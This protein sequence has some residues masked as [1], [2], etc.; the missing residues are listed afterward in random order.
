M[1]LFGIPEKT[2]MRYGGVAHAERPARLSHWTGRALWERC[3][4]ARETRTGPH[5]TPASCGHCGERY[6]GG[7]ADGDVALSLT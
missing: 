3:G 2:A 1:R 4:P 5:R 7:L 6:L